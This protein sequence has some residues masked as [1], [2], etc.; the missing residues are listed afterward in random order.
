LLAWVCSVN[1]DATHASSCISPDVGIDQA[2]REQSVIWH[3]L[4]GST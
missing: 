1:C 2:T 4:A 3:W